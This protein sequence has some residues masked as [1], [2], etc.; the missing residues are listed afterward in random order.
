MRIG[1]SKKECYRNKPK[2]SKKMLKALEQ[3][4]L[5]PGYQELPQPDDLEPAMLMFL[6]FLLGQGQVAFNQRLVE[7]LADEFAQGVV[8]SLARVQAFCRDCCPERCRAD[9]RQLLS[10]N[11]QAFSHLP[12]QVGRSTRER[13]SAT[14]KWRRE[15]AEVLVAALGTSRQV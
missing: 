12:C 3:G 9:Q 11:F 2:H 15:D 5:P 6:F 7:R 10:R 1:T 14:G 8:V 4:M 13:N